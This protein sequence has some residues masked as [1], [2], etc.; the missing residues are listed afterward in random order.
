MPP[1]F[2]RLLVT[3]NTVVVGSNSLAIAAACHV[4]PLVGQ[5]QSRPGRSDQEYMAGHQDENMELRH[6]MGPSPGLLTRDDQASESCQDE[7]EWMAMLLRVSQ[8]KIRWGVV[9][10]P[11][12]WAEQFVR[13]DPAVEHISFGLSEDDVETPVV[14]H[15]YA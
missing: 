15:W 9:K 11:P 8:S 3:P 12:S 10:M 14:G 7:E 4:S 1:I 2:G 5:N 13:R 6:L